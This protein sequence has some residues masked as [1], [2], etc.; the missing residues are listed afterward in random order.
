MQMDALTRYYVRRAALE[1]MQH[2]PSLNV[3]V[4][5]E[6]EEKDV[7]KEQTLNLLKQCEN[8]LLAGEIIFDHE[9]LI[10][11]MT[12]ILWEVGK[13]YASF[14]RHEVIAASAMA[15]LGARITEIVK[16]RLE[17]VA[18]WQYEHGEMK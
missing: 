6:P 16:L 4:P 14:Q 2:R 17:Q 10:N 3:Y 1:M 15:L 18:R 13:A 12:E 5:D 11:D 7:V 8:H 9:L